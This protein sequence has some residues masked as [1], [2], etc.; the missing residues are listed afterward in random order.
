MTGVQTCALPIW[1]NYYKT[2]YYYSGDCS[3]AAEI[4]VQGETGNTFCDGETV[5]LDAGTGFVSYE[6]S[7]GETTQT[8]SVNKLG[9][10]SVIVK[11]ANN[12]HDN[13]AI[14]IFFTKP[15]QD[16]KICMVTVE[17][18]KN[19]I[20]WAPAPNKG[21][22]EY[23]IYKETNMAG[24]FDL[25]ATVGF[26]NAGEYIDQNSNALEKGAC[27]AISVVD[28]CGNESRPSPFHQT[29]HLNAFVGQNGE[30]H[31]I[32]EPYHGAP[33][34]SYEIY[35]GTSATDLSLLTTVSASFM[36]YT[37][38][39][40]PSGM[41]YYRVDAVGF[42]CPVKRTETK[43]QSNIANNTGGLPDGIEDLTAKQLKVYPN[44]FTNTTT[45]QLP[46][47]SA[48]YQLRII[49]MLGNVI[50]YHEDISGNEFTLQKGNLPKGMYMLELRGKTTRKSLIIIQ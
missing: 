19:K 42:N 35:R 43:S 14:Q 7:T 40:A 29:I 32:W 9:T 50:R 30:T 47:N 22:A 24:D 5:T 25:L 12:C 33:F 6:W 48:S 20:V 39:D 16:T 13:A 17:N 26:A 34:A 31:L 3:V 2:N 46:D 15:F 23:N 4:T 49:D 28:E 45:I 18:D 8:I 27:Y 1:V 36:S 21:I 37:D 44:P 41:L 10:Y 11:D 38:L